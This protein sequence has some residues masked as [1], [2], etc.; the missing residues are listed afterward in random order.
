MIDWNDAFDNSGYIDGAQHY[1]DRWS[2]RAANARAQM[3]GELNVSY[4]QNVRECFDLFQP[5]EQ[6]SGL[7]IYIHGGFWH[8]FD[9]S[10]W[11]QLALGPYAQGWSVAVVGYPLAPEVTV[12]EITQSIASAVTE[13]ASRVAGPIVLTGHSAGGH[14]VSRLASSSSPLS[15]SIKKRMQKVVSISGVHDL[16]PLLMTEMNNTLKL[17]EQSAEAESPSLD[18]PHKHLPCCFWVGADERPEFLRQNR[19]IAESWA[20]QGG[21]VS[22]VYEP[23]TQHFT[24]VESLQYAD[25]ALT[26]ELL[27]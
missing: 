1:A 26:M 27:S 13:A 25:G 7:V 12:P 22:S 16:R 8:R 17:T 14:L 15:A 21:S 4:G 9:K 20:R 23:G 5:S 6:S 11:S 24:V 10:Y 18:S 3:R 19:L 2:E